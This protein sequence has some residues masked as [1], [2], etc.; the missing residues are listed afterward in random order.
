MEPK[1][2]VIGNRQTADR[3]ITAREF[4]GNGKDQM[5][6]SLRSNRN[7]LDHLSYGDHQQQT[8]KGDFIVVTFEIGNMAGV[9][10]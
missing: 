4:T 6:I 8:A 7:G 10:K 2:K 1:A 5:T 3:K 9:R